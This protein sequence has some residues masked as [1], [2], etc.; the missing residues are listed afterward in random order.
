MHHSGSDQRSL[1]LHRI[2][3]LLP[4]VGDVRQPGKVVGHNI[5]PACSV[6]DVELEWL[7]SEVPSGETAG[8]VL[9]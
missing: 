7:E 9:H 3:P 2:I 1:A 5:V 6:S 8:V 4:E